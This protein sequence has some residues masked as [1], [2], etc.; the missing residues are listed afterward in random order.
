MAAEATIELPLVLRESLGR[1]RLPVTAD[2][3]EGAIE[4]ACVR[5]PALRMHLF[6]DAGRFRPHVLCFHNGRDTRELASLAVP[7]ANGDRIAFLQA[8]SGG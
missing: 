1:R 6:E 3:L 5:W 8:I 4:A 7:L 2:T